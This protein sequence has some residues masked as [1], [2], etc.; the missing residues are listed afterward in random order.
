MW[1]QMTALCQFYNLKNLNLQFLLNDRKK[2]NR[3]T[4]SSQG[5]VRESQSYGFFEQGSI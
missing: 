3:Y 2:K 1:C 4:S 5:K